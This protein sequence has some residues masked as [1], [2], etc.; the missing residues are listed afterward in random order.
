MLAR[1][2]YKDPGALPFL[3]IADRTMTGVYAESGYNVGT[4][5]MMLRIMDAVMK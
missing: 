3:L 2:M 4:G 1:R 5:E